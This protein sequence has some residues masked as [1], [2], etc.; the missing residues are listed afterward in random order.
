ML[1][2]YY[3]I[4]EDIIKAHSKR[5][6]SI[7]RNPQNV[8]K[9][10]EMIEYIESAPFAVEI[11]DIISAAVWYFFDIHASSNAYSIYEPI[12][13]LTYISDW[14]LTALTKAYYIYPTA[15]LFHKIDYDL[16]YTNW[17]VYQMGFMEIIPQ[18]AEEHR[19]L[20]IID[21]VKKHR[22][23]EDFQEDRESKYKTAFMDQWYHR[24]TKHPEV[25]IS[26]IQGPFDEDEGQYT[27]ELADPNSRFQEDAENE[28]M[29]ESFLSRLNE[30]DKQIL[31]LRLDNYTYEEI[32][33]MLG[34]KTHSAVVKRIKRIGEAYQKYAKTDL[35]FE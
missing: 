24:R 33:E 11:A 7:P 34:Y 22:C 26:E 4:P 27:Y 8:F 17:A 16:P 25:I 2:F 3:F 12:W 32:A 5:F 1:P 35:G 28:V 20:P 30:K 13:N 29:I 10:M 19:L 23:F 31:Q 14:Y 15:Y 6:Q 9:D 21:Y 18:V